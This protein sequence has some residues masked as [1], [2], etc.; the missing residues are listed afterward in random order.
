M[1]HFL[2]LEDCVKEKR[3]AEKEG[4]N[5]K[6]A[7]LDEHAKDALR[8]STETHTKRSKGSGSERRS[9]LP[10]GRRS[11]SVNFDA[12]MAA[13]TDFARVAMEEFVERNA[14]LEWVRHMK[15]HATHPTLADHLGPKDA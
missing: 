9:G 2:D 11:S 1:Q 6:L 14:R 4:K 10:R 13:V 5:T 15:L 3:T 8:R 7:R 12:K